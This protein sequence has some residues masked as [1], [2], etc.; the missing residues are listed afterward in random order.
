LEF[1]SSWHT[2]VF[3]IRDALQSAVL[4]VGK[5]FAKPYYSVALILLTFA[6]FARVYVICITTPITVKTILL[7]TP[8]AG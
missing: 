2:T 4:I 1:G 3:D 6:I 7:E 8:K 5:D